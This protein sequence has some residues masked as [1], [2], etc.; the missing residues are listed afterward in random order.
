MVLSVGKNTFPPHI[1]PEVGQKLQIPQADDQKI[2]AQAMEMVKEKLDPMLEK[3][4]RE[5][6]VEM[7]EKK[8]KQEIDKIVN[9]KTS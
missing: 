3:I 6:V 7:A 4:A 2:F 1:Q 8:I 5:V 9:R